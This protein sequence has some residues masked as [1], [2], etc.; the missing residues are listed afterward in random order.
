MTTSREAF[1]KWHTKQLDGDPDNCPHE[2]HEWFAW[3]ASRAALAAESEP[4]PFDPTLPVTGGRCPHGIYLGTYKS[5]HKCAL[6]LIDT[7]TRALAAQGV[8]P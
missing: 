8:E 4:E 3:Q 1:E 6:G 2:A 7:L 5:C